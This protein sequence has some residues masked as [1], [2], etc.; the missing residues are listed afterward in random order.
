M[1]Q[2]PTQPSHQLPLRKVNHTMQ[3]TPNHHHLIPHFFHL[4]QTK[5]TKSNLRHTTNHTTTPNQ[6]SP[7]SP[8][9]QIT[10]PSSA[11]QIT[12]HPAVPQITYPAQ[13]NTN[14]KSKPKPT[15]SLYLCLNSKGA[16]NKL[17][18]SQHM[19]QSLKSLEAQ[20]LILAASDNAETT[21]EK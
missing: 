19:A 18:P 21:T 7:P 4:K 6:P 8:A 15:H 9:S 1:E 13:N 16:N 11:P 10:Y 12:Y 20:T 3:W 2:E 5:A 14:P 17:M